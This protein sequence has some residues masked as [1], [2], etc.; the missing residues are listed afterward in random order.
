M[1]QVLLY[2]WSQQEEYAK[3]YPITAGVVSL[4]SPKENILP[5]VRQGVQKNE[6]IPAIDQVFVSEIQEFITE[7]IQE[8][9]DEQNSF[10]SL[11]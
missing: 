9:F 5:V 6:N 4:K 1:F 7:L 2:A 11:G 3:E 8:I 10:V